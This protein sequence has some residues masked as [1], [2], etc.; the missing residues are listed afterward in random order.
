MNV[1]KQ[2]FLLVGAGKR[3]AE[4]AL[5]DSTAL[6]QLKES[7]HTANDQLIKLRGEIVNIK[8][9]AKTAQARASELTSKAN[10]YTDTAKQL[11]A[12]HDKAVEA[13]NDA[14]AAKMKEL[15][16]SALKDRDQCLAEAK[17]KSA[18]AEGLMQS[19]TKLEATCSQ[20]EALLKRIDTD[21]QQISTTQTVL[22]ARQAVNNLNSSV[23]TGSAVAS[24][25]RLKQRQMEQAARLDVADEQQIGMGDGKYE[26]ALS[27]DTS[28]YDDE[29]SKL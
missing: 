12:K 5:L 7:R 20:Q 4:E 10:G 25:E 19:V 29:F 18:E 2:L 13:K 11:K 14:D 28:N 27:K 9:K 23:D 22:N 6:I 26:A 15:T 8:A 16:H 24:V 21:I 17:I 1:F 3:Q